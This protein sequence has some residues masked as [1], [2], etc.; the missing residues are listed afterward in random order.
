M[1]ACES[2]VT[3]SKNYG[4]DSRVT[5]IV[6]KVSF[7][8]IPVSNPDGYQYTH[9]TERLWRKNLRDNNNDGFIDNNDGVDLNR[10]W[11]SHW[12]L[13][14]EGS[15]DSPSS[16]TYRGP[17]PIS[18]PA[19]RAVA[20]FMWNRD[21]KYMIS[22]HSYGNLILYPVGWQLTTPS[23][24]DAI[25]VAQSGVIG[26]ASVFDSLQSE[27]YRPS[28]SADLYTT[29]GEFTDWAY[30]DLGVP[31][32]TVELTKGDDGAGN[33]YGFE[34]P[35]DAAMLNTLFEDNLDFALAV[36]ESA[37]N[38]AKPTAPTGMEARNMYHEPIKRSYGNAQRII[39]T[40][41][42]RK[43]GM[44]L[45]YSVNGDTNRA[46]FRRVH[47]KDFNTQSGVHYD[48]FQAIIE[49]Q[50]PG[51]EVSYWIVRKGEKLGPY[52]YTVQGVDEPRVLV[53][54][55]EDYSS[56]RNNNPAYVDTTQPNYLH[57]YTEALTAADISYN[58]Y[59][60]DAEK[61]V[62]SIYGT[63][64]NHD[65]VIWYTG[66]DFAS[67]ALPN[68]EGHTQTILAIR[69]YL[70]FCDG[71]VLVTGQGLSYLSTIFNVNQDDFFQYTLGSFI[72]LRGG[73]QDDAGEA[74]GLAGAAGDPIF[75]GV[76][77]SLKGGTGA[78]NQVQAA[79]F[80]LTRY[81]LPDFEFDIAAKYDRPGNPFGPTSGQ[82]YLYSQQADVS[83]K[84]LGGTYM[85]PARW[86]SG[87]EFTNV[88]RH[89]DRLG[90]TPR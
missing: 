11:A 16:N 70:N 49:D 13:D 21:F 5:N 32:Y 30:E 15:S 67:R 1:L 61:A 85:L 57:F 35:D 80:L 47:G 22:Y 62:P 7:W 69:D 9:T 26:N 27:H 20:N 6:N 56:G 73:G 63:L 17:S 2:Y 78:N 25:F 38:P 3:Y 75:D 82:Y 74:F 48:R 36:I 42:N 77:L 59:D 52:N 28:V 29:N 76:Q 50:R 64:C 40:A 8:S 51:D 18:E 60:I 44:R 24:D 19:N 72:T 53:I 45:Y 46:R 89:R 58:V 65:A 14:N 31:S 33:S 87:N 79:S 37:R 54:A 10:N 23:I 34:F 86:Q 39:V 84:R 41:R 88:L 43:K 83:Y 66:N 81:F 90:I 4:S 12:G 55:A 71:K 68:F